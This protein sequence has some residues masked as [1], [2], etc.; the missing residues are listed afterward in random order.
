[1]AVFVADVRDYDAVSKAINETEPID[2]LI[3]GWMCNEFGFRFFFF[4]LFTRSAVWV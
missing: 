2:V 4:F 3:Y 1:V